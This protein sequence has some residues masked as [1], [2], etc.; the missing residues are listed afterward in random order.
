MEANTGVSGRWWS[1]IHQCREKAANR[2]RSGEKAKDW[3][4]GTEAFFKKEFADWKGDLVRGNL[5]QRDYD[6][7]KD[8]LWA[9]DPKFSISADLPGFEA[10]CATVEAMSIKVWNEVGAFEELETAFGQALFENIAWVALDYDRH[11]Q[12]PKPRWVSGFVAVDPLCKGMLR[13]ARWVAEVIER[14]LID[15][16]TDTALPE[17]KRKKI[18]ETYLE[19]S[20]KFD[21]DVM[22]RMAYIWSRF[23]P[24]P[25]TPNAITGRKLVIICDKLQEPV[26]VAEW[27]WPF[28]DPDKFPLY[29]LS[30]KKIPGEIEGVTIFELLESLFRH[31]NWAASFNLADAKRTAQKKILYDKGKVREQQEQAKFESGKHLELIGAYG[32]DIQNAAH[33]MDFGGGSDVVYRTLELSKTLHDDQSGITDTI[34][35]M[36]TGGR[37]TAE[38][39]RSNNQNASIVFKGIQKVLNRFSNDFIHDFVVAICYFIPAWSRMVGQDGQIWTKQ[40]DEATGQ[41]YDAVC[42]PVEV[43]GLGAINP[44]PGTIV[45]PGVDAFLGPER[46][47]HWPEYDTEQLKRDFSFTIEAGSSRADAMLDEQ[48]NTL[49]MMQTLGPTY[50]QMGL[51]PQYFELAKRFIMSFRPK[52]AYKLLP[53][54]DAM[55]QMQQMQM[56]NQARD[57]AMQLMQS[58]MMGGQ[59]GQAGPPGSGNPKAGSKEPMNMLGANPSKPFGAPGASQGGGAEAKFSARQSTAPR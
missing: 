35:G 59:P 49:A 17:D 52:D 19:K 37:Q 2:L 8:S 4:R 38:E 25:W 47:Y 34:K 28:L 9:D 12:M 46:A 44:V 18:L 3:Y 16:Y 26:D 13:R 32:P 48:R 11:R 56:W 6:I 53:P 58:G 21:P 15:V 36:P 7:L 10:S 29:M 39:T 51:I 54:P 22:V 55:Y 41:L 27:P 31:F 23:G 1:F 43:Q 40:K 30:L 20:G 24:E 57:L 45:K 5:W 33:V 42:D 50:Q 14:P